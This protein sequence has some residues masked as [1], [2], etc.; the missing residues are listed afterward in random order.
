VERIFRLFQTHA[1]PQDFKG[2]VLHLRFCPSW[3]FDSELVC[4]SRHPFDRGVGVLDRSSTVPLPGFPLSLLPSRR[5]SSGRV[6]CVAR[7]FQGTHCHEGTRC[8]IMLLLVGHLADDKRGRLLAWS[9]FSSLGFTYHH[10][11]HLHKILGRR[12]WRIWPL[13]TMWLP[14]L[15]E[16]GECL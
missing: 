2:F 12:I 5:F 15:S 8:P 6:C 10:S 9:A 1:F 4:G 11:G 3:Q 7:C 14:W 13:W 16:L